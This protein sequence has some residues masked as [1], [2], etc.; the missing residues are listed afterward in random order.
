MPAV[1]AFDVDYLSYLE[2]WVENGHAPDLMIGA[3]PKSETMQIGT[4]YR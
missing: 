2:A 3:H 1:G 4:N